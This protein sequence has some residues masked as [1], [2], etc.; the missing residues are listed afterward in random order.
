MKYIV[1]Q[2]F[3]RNGEQEMRP[4]KFQIGDNIVVLNIG[5]K[6]PFTKKFCVRGISIKENGVFYMDENAE[7][8]NELSLFCS[9]TEAYN[10]IINQC[11]S[12]LMAFSHAERFSRPQVV[13][14][15]QQEKIVI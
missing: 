11:E 3:E 1:V 4:T 8:V 10:F 13:P 7:W 14:V 5:H 12:E 6:L 9:K 2:G 15:D